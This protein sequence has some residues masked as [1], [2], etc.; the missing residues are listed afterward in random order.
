[1]G[2]ESV[3]KEEEKSATCVDVLDNKDEE[4]GM[5]C[6]DVLDNKEE[7]ETGARGMEAPADGKLV[8]RDRESTERPCEGCIDE[9]DT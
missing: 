6:V 5:A 4:R 2:A 1:M 3:D 7:E 9:A 8:A